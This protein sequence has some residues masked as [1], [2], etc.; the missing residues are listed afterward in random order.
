MSN[1]FFQVRTSQGN[2]HDREK[3]P[4]TALH[5]QRPLGRAGRLRLLLMKHIH[6][7]AMAAD[8]TVCWACLFSDC[9]GLRHPGAERR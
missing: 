5:K 8:L 3:I 7:K 9:T 4:L 2:K 1:A 6:G